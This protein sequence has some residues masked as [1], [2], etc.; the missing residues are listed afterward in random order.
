MFE[1]EPEFEMT[2][3][4]KIADQGYDIKYLDIHGDKPI[5]KKNGDVRLDF[6][7]GYIDWCDTI[8]QLN[9]INYLLLDDKQKEY[10][11]GKKQSIEVAERIDLTEPLVFNAEEVKI[12]TVD[13]I[14][15][16][17]DYK[18][19]IELNKQYIEKNSELQQRLND[20]RK[21]NEQQLIQYANAIEVM[22]V[23]ELDYQLLVKM[24]PKF[25][26]ADISMDLTDDEIK[27]IKE[28]YG[29]QSNE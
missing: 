16:V 10:W 2:D 8:E 4:I 1:E 24:I 29:G 7:K 12:E 6:F 26:E 23:N 13:G 15:D 21:E 9:K 11:K 22:E 17:K 3:D 5:F 19:T 18:K 27:R 25:V 28:L 20:L 14:V